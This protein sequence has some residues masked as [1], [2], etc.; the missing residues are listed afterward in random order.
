MV[1]PLFLSDKNFL[2]S[3]SQQKVMKASSGLTIKT[4]QRG[5]CSS[6][7]SLIF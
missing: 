2:L 7:T 1:Q 5:A 4:K 6:A 3:S